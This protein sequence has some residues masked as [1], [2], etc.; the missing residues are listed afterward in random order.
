MGKHFP[1]NEDLKTAFS[2]KMVASFDKIDDVESNA[3]RAS[4]KPLLEIYNPVLQP[5]SGKVVAVSEFYEIADEFKYSLDQVRLRSWLAV[6][7]FMLT[8][9]WSYQPSCSAGAGQSTARAEP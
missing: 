6:T 5:W 3:E 1:V 7:I 8:F 4:G 9:S 2:G